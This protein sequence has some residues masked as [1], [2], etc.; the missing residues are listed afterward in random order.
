MR[1]FLFKIQLSE[2]IKAIYW[3]SPMTLKRNLII[4]AL[5][6]IVFLGLVYFAVFGRALRQNENHLGIAFTIPKALLS[7]VAVSVD[8][9]TYLARNSEAFIKKMEREG[10]EKVEQLGSAYIFGKD[11]KRYISSGRMY[12]KYFMVFTRPEER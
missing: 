11:G 8:D 6:I 4:A 12:S 9:E 5:A 3:F 7:S 10:F 2:K 1:F